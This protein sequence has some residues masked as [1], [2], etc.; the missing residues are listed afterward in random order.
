MVNNDGAPHN[1]HLHGVGFQVL[2]VSGGAPPPEL[3]GWKDTV[4]L[5][6][7]VPYEFIIAFGAYADPRTPYM[8]HCHLLY[9]E[10]QGMMAQ[11][12]VT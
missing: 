7:H 3:A 10:D 9:H 1:L 4:F 12:L 6:P 8:F 2:T 5:K 11:F